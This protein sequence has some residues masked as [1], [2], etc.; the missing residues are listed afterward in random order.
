MSSADKKV[1]WAESR[2]KEI[3]TSEILEGNITDDSDWQDVYYSFAEYQKYEKQNFR[4]NMKNLLKALTKKENSAL[5]DLQAVK[6]DRTCY[7][8]EEV[9]EQGYPFWDTSEASKLLKVDFDKD[10][11]KKQSLDELWNSREAYKMFPKEV[12]SKHIYQ[13]KKNRLQK[14]YWLSKNK[15]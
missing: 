15:K 13:E 3:L 5:F 14:S 2:A 7:P 9:T 8:R 6:D 12:F 4:S 10:I 1:P 11:I